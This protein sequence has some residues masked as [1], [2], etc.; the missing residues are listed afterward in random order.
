[1]SGGRRGDHETWE[2]RLYNDGLNTREHVSQS[3]VPRNMGGPI[4]Q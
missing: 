2:V 1:M 4:V 3:L